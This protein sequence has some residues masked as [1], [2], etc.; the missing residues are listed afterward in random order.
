MST[1]AVSGRSLAK[2]Y[3]GRF[4]VPDVTL[5]VAWGEILEL[6]RSDKTTTVEPFQELRRPEAR[7]ISVLG[8]DRRTQPCVMRRLESSQLQDCAL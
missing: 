5:E 7:D 1:S 8:L 6:I 4:P 3:G 2:A